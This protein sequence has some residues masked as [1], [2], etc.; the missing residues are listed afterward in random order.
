MN[1]PENPEPVTSVSVAE[2]KQRFSELLKKAAAGET[3]QITKHG[4]PYAKL[5]MGG[6][7]LPN[8]R[9]LGTFRNV[10]FRMSDDFDDLGPEWDPY[11]P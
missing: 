9:A 4:R 8:R 10:R 2:A 6:D 7:D 11:V 3:I 5:V 1:K